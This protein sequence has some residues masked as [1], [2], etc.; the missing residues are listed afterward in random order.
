MPTR[1]RYAAGTP[2]WVDLMS[3]DVDASTAFYTE[4][5]GWDAEDQHD[6]EGERIYT[7]FRQ[8]GHDVAGAGGQPPDL[9]GMPPVWNTYVAVDDADAT[10]DAARRAGG[11]VMMEPMEV[12]DAGRMAILGDP[13]GA[14]I[15]VW[16]AG[17]HIGAGLV[18]EPNSYSWSEL[19][20]RDRDGVRGFY[21]QTFGWKLED[22][23]MGPMGIYVVAN[24]GDAQVAGLMAMPDTIPDEVPNYW[25]V[26]F[27]VADA[28]AIC[29]RAASLGGSVAWGPQDSPVGRLATV[30]DAGGGSFSIMQHPDHADVS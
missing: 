29:S 7:M 24:V 4:L 27:T 23:D 9:A 25:N 28:D 3:P 6:D 15:C 17:A 12:M 26:Y 5:F 16:Q 10:A 8:D 11:S 2:S 13:T 30:Q 22:Q 19:V 21:E 14:T 18:N 20:T 1:D